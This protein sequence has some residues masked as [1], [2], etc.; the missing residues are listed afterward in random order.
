VKKI[1]TGKEAPE[2][3]LKDQLQAEFNETLAKA[4]ERFGL[5]PEFETDMLKQ[6]ESSERFILYLFCSLLMVERYDFLRQLLHKLQ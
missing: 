1:Q 6:V 3:D 2:P 4:K 5:R